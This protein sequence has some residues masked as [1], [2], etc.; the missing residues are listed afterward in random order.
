M[1][2]EI[3]TQNTLDVIERLKLAK[4]GEYDKWEAI[5]KKLRKGIP[6]DSQEYQYFANISRMYKKGRTTSH[7]KIY[8][9]KL[10]EIDDKPQCSSCNE[11]SQFY[12]NMNDAYFCKVH[13]VGHDENEI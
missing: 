7:S 9:T 13:V 4:V 3:D 11:E 10:S 5:I 6:M 12:C 1:T 8:H 2:R